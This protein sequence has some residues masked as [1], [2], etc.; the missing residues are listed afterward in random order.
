MYIFNARK[1]KSGVYILS[2]L[3]Y[4]VFQAVI[5]VYPTYFIVRSTQNLQFY[6]ISIC[7]RIKQSNKFWLQPPTQSVTIKN[8][9]I[10]Y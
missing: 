3:R 9:Y 5:K 1:G 7:C 2:L 6:N 8:E 10:I 4:R